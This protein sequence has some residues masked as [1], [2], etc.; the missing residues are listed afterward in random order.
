MPSAIKLRT[1]VRPGSF[2]GW[3]TRP[4]TSTRA[5]DCAYK[6]PSLASYEASMNMRLAGKFYRNKAVGRNTVIK[7][8]SF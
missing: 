8:K 3:P 1:D 4:R 5:D 7:A 6:M 2:G